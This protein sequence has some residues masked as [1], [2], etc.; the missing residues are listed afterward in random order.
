M[1]LAA[2]APLEVQDS[3]P[4]SP[5]EG[6]D[7]VQE[8][9]PKEEPRSPYGNPDRYEVFGQTY[10][11][12]DSAQGYSEEGIASWYG[13]KFHGERTSSGE[14]YDMYALTAAHT[15]LPLPTYVRVTHLENDRSI[16][17]RVNDR[18]PF[19]H[20]RII[21][22]SY[23]A[24]HRLDMADAGTAPVRVEALTGQS[25]QAQVGDEP[26]HI[27]VGAF[28]DGDN[29]QDLKR[30]LESRDITPIRIQQE[31]NGRRA[32]HRVQVGPISGEQ[33]VEN[34]LQRLREA[35]IHETRLIRS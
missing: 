18:G 29:A 3:G 30:Q 26:V 13:K 34:L 24:A 32:V 20:N 11:V 21:D 23:A 22:L 31:G 2:C 1:L 9:I 4:S 17:V 10:H 16:V 8:P 15:S 6:L 25:G 5:P 19:A 14:T 28:R 12:L 27:Q 33:N 35:G 7:Q